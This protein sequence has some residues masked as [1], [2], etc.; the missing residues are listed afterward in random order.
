MVRLKSEDIKGYFKKGTYI[1]GNLL[2]D[3]YGES[4]NEAGEIAFSE[5]LE[6]GIQNTIYSL[7]DA[8]VNDDE[9]IRVLNKVWGINK[10]E[11]EDRI[12]YEKTEATIRELEHY[13]KMQGWSYAKIK[14]FKISNMV[15]TKIRNNTDLWK[16]RYRPEKLMQE[17]QKEK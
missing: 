11:A 9:I 14:E 3:I 13:L 17:V 6:M 2:K 4:L 12:I 8:N 15:G 16:L 7:Y 10:S 1:I 5:A